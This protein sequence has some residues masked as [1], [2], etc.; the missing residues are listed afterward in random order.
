MVE[1]RSEGG[2]G[3]VESLSERGGLVESR[4]EGGEAKECDC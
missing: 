1:S 2:G 3:V 4:S